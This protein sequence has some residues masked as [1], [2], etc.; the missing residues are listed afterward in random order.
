MQI[1]G[2]TIFTLISNAIDQDVWFLRFSLSPFSFLPSL[3]SFL[4]SLSF[5]L[6]YFWVDTLSY[7]CYN[8]FKWKHKPFRISA[9]FLGLKS[10]TW[11]QALAPRGRPASPAPSPHSWL[12]VSR[13]THRLSGSW[14][15]Q[16]HLSFI[17]SLVGAFLLA[18]SLRWEVPACH[19]VS[20]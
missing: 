18:I 10:G 4:L 6:K 15:F 9:S 5:F 16:V 1:I 2:L 7:V 12:T 17:S 3:P 13:H 14:M 20:A 19:L 8:A 11:P